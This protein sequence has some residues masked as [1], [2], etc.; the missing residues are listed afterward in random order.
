QP[1]HHVALVKKGQL[2]GDARQL[3][4]AQARLPGRIFTMLEIRADGFVTVE[5]VDGEQEEDAEV[6]NEDGPIE[7]RQPVNALEGI[8]E[9]LVRPVRSRCRQKCR[10][11]PTRYH[12]EPLRREFRS[13]K[14]YVNRSCDLARCG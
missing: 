3:F 1:F 13:K 14:S 8:V 12:K 2:D 4:E 6:G 9:K 5:A 7:Q 11:Q 10:N